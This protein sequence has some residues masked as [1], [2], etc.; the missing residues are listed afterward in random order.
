M[1][2]KN[3]VDSSV[4]ERRLRPIYNWLDDGNNKKALQEAE[5][6]LK[7]QPNFQCAKVL[8][9]LALLRLGKEIECLQLLDSVR[10]DFQCDDSTLQAMTICYRE[11]N[12]PEMICDIY[13][14]ASKKEPKNEELLTHLFMAYVRVCNYKKQ[15]QT[16][17]TLYKLKLKNHYYFWAVMSIVMQAHEAGPELANSVQLPLA[18]K[19]VMKF[20]KDD[21]IE[22]EQEVQLYLMILEMQN[23]LEDAIQ[24]VEGPLGEMLHS[25]LTVPTKRVELLMKMECWSRANVEIK[26]IL[27]DDMDNWTLYLNYFQTVSHTVDLHASSNGVSDYNSSDKTISDCVQFLN[28]IQ[29]KNQDTKHPLRGPYLAILELY[30]QLQEKGIDPNVHF[31]EIT[32]LLQAYFYCFGSKSCVLND[33]RPYL[34]ALTEP[35]VASFLGGIWKFIGLED[36]QLPTSREQM[37]RYISNLHISRHLGFHDKLTNSAKMQLSDCLLRYYFHGAQ[38]N[39]QNLLATDVRHNDPFIILIVEIMNDLWMETDNSVYLRKAIAILEHALSKSPSNHQFKVLLIK[40]YNVLGVS[41]A[42][43]KVYELLDV[44]HVQLDSMGYLMCTPLLST[45]LYYL[46]SHLIEL[47]L[48]FFTSNYKDSADHLTFLYKFGS[49]TKIHEFIKFRERLNNSLH[50]SSVTVEKMLL[51]I[52]LAS[53]YQSSLQMIEQMSIQPEKESISFHSLE[54]NRDLDLCWTSNPPSKQLSQELIQTSFQNEVDF[55]RT[56]SITLRIIG[57]VVQLA[58][59]NKPRTVENGNCEGVSF[60]QSEEESMGTL[61]HLHQEIKDLFTSLS[62]KKISKLPKNVILTPSDSRL[63]YFLELPFFELLQTLLHIVLI[64]KVEDQSTISKEEISAIEANPVLK[65]SEAISILNTESKSSDYSQLELR[66]RFLNLLT[67]IVE[68]VSISCL[69]CGVMFEL[70]KPYN[71]EKIKK[72]KKKKDSSV[73]SL[74]YMSDKTSPSTLSVRV[75][76][77]LLTVTQKALQ[78]LESVVNATEETWKEPLSIDSD[79]TNLM[80][81]LSLESIDPAGVSDIC[82]VEELAFDSYHSSLTEINNILKVKTKFLSDLQL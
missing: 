8:K 20:V 27:I 19:M 44:K 15:Q 79:V 45:G 21:K 77:K 37:L 11:M 12:Q 76:H 13:S 75:A 17:M 60:K 61:K 31:G 49:F 53:S 5:K 62:Q 25:S 28:A 38:F 35:Q 80:T 68:M 14:E 70:A 24:V 56:R 7:K 2:S 23:K 1:A 16:A 9:G 57:G 3:H 30:V 32:E 67:V 48:K 43:E 72:G 59:K 54:D 71:V 50:Y 51:E 6:V 74:P 52:F 58:S 63:F 39:S 73:S 29:K 34:N 33:L 41:K 82:R 47:T 78:E 42:A 64:M 18:E 40:L 65:L 10:K 26:K 66:C 36:G 69:F 46:G 81:T 55:L 4:A 22:A